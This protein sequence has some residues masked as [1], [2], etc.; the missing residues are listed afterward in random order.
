MT[1]VSHAVHTPDG[2]RYMGGYT[3]DRRDTAYFLQTTLH[4][5]RQAARRY[6][7]KWLEWRDFNRNEEL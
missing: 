4:N 5:T 2:I 7:R 3:F 6:A 1:F